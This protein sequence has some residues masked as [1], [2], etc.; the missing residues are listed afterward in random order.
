MVLLPTDCDQADLMQFV[1]CVKVMGHICFTSNQKCWTGIE[2]AFSQPYLL[3]DPS[4][5]FTSLKAMLPY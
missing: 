3:I 4:L 2:I 5:D 1:T